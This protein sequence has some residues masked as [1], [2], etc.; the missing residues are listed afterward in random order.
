MT[1]KQI[2]YIRVSSGDQNTAR[3]FEGIALDKTYRG[4]LQEGTEFPSTSL[5][6]FTSLG[7][8]Q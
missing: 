4:S 7:C 3:Q 6:P 2:G 1:G 5:K 8:S